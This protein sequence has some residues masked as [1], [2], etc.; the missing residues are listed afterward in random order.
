MTLGVEIAINATVEIVGGLIFVILA[1]S[2]YARGDTQIKQGQVFMQMIVLTG[3]LFF[4]DAVAQIL[5]GQEGEMFRSI[6]VVTNFIVYLFSCFAMVAYVRY[7]YYVLSFKA[8]APRFIYYLIG[9]LT[10]IYLICIVITQFN[11]MIYS[12]SADNRYILGDGYIFTL[13]YN[14]FMLSCSGAIIL[15]HRRELG[16]HDTFVLSSYAYLPLSSIVLHFMYPEI[17]FSFVAFLLSII[18]I[19][20]NF[21][22]QQSDALKIKMAESR[23]A[24]MLSQ[25][26]PH[27]L[28]N[29]LT[30]IQDLCRG[31][32]TAQKAVLTFSKYLRTNMDS[33]FQKEPIA[34]EKELDHVEQY[35]SLEKL[36][37]EERLSVVY[38]IQAID[39]MMPTLTLQPIVENAVQHGVMQREEGGR[40][41]IRTAEEADQYVISVIDDGVGFDP[42]TEKDD[43]R[44]HAGIANVR[45]RLKAMCKGTLSFQSKSGVGTTA[46][47]AIPKEESDR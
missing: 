45:M 1:V 13:F 27:F 4:S 6:C 43:G 24:I 3:A 40:I 18:I 38:E 44:S 7:I 42:D 29:S 23:T 17:M 9:V 35:L 2:L 11:G 15:Q 12:V 36:R 14:V 5:D 39:F 28:Y 10:T 47:I 41:I 31:N 32:P 16:R 21:Q 37:Y 20:I 25:I 34:F 8:K 22:T 26:Q 30:A 46:T 33:L 19:Y